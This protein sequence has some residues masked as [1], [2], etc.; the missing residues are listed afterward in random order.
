[1]IKPPYCSTGRRYWLNLFTGTT[2]E[3]FL[4]DS[5]RSTGFRSH[6]LATAK[7]IQIGDYFLCYL[8]GLSRFI[9]VL[10]AMSEAEVSYW[11]PAWG[12]VR[13]PIT[14]SVKP[15]YTLTPETAV[16]ILILK[17]SLS[18]FDDLKVPRAWGVLFRGSP[19]EFNTSDGELIV[20]AIRGAMDRPIARP[21][22]ERDYLRDPVSSI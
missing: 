14:F 11:H 8:A 10:E 19:R 15:V 5:A 13:F 1:M 3:A 22:R 6:K 18:M 20:E 2:W 7:K 17:D 12:D 16:P 21:Y 4:A 9:S